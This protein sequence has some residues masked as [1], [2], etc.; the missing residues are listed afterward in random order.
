MNLGKDIREFL[1][2]HEPFIENGAR[3]YEWEK[4]GVRFRVVAR[5]VKREGDSNP[6]QLSKPLNN[7]IIT[8][9]SDRN[10]KEK[11]K[12]KN[13]ELKSSFEL[14]KELAQKA[15]L[16]KDDGTFHKIPPIKNA[17]YYQNVEKITQARYD[18]NFLK[19]VLKTASWKPNP[20]EAVEF[21]L[22]DYK[23]SKPQEHIVQKALNAKDLNE[24]TQ[25]KEFVIN[26]KN[27]LEAVNQK[28]EDDHKLVVQ[29]FK[30]DYAEDLAR[31]EKKR[32][33]EE[34]LTRQAIAKRNQERAEAEAEELR[35]KLDKM[36][37]DN[38]KELKKAGLAD[39]YLDDVKMD[40]DFIVELSERYSKNDLKTITKKAKGGNY[41]AR[42]ILENYDT[43]HYGRGYGYGYSMSNNAIDAYENGLKPISKWN[44][45]DAKELSDLLGVEVK[46]KDLKKFLVEFG[47]RGEHHTSKYFNSTKFYSIA[48]AFNNAGK[49][50]LQKYFKDA[51]V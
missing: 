41:L 12:F 44:A 7:D 38:L 24:L 23:K 39:V 34:E 11:M 10:L 20:K 25:I 19:E 48:E 35:T 33:Q 49:E 47:V 29:N 31:I 13:P 2:E 40:V 32:E 22:R 45:K 15:G 46:L 42:Q 8:F 1:Q 9:Y 27:K 28:I 30:S 50:G 16:M 21:V 4:D 3:L 5:G 17:Q 51:L 43:A 26:K 14:A 36:N 37:A 18:N 6:P